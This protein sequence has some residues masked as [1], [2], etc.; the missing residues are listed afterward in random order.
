MAIKKTIIRNAILV[1]NLFVV[2]LNFFPLS[3]KMNDV[4]PIR[5]SS[6]PRYHLAEGGY[7]DVCSIRY[8]EF[9]AQNPE[10]HKTMPKASAVVSIYRQVF[11]FM[12]FHSSFL[13][14]C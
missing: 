2:C 3:K 10:K 8:S 7:L 12:F 13:L 6:T 11:W 5:N 4:S 9:I 1:L 14:P